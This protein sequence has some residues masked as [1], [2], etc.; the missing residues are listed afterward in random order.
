MVGNVVKNYVNVYFSDSVFC[1][2]T[3]AIISLIISPNPDRSED[4]YIEIARLPVTD[5]GLLAPE[6]YDQDD[7]VD[8]LNVYVDKIAERMGTTVI[9]TDGP[10]DDLYWALG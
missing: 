6:D 8:G 7:I 1:F 10:G 2:H 9:G 5:F 4:F 3:K